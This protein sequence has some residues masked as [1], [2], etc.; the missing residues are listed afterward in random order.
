MPSAEIRPEKSDDSSV[1]N[2]HNPNCVMGRGKQ[3]EK[4]R[5]ELASSELENEG[6]KN[7]EVAGH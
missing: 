5:C 1:T 6:D 3:E 4:K 7:A 2:T